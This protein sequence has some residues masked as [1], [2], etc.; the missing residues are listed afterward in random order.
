ME[1]KILIDASQA[2]QTRVAITNNGNVG[3]VGDD[4]K[5]KKEKMKN[6]A[7]RKRKR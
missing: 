7:K 6:K 1:K 3:D 5:S 2:K 4:M